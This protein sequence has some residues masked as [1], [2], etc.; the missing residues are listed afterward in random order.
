MQ[1]LIPPEQQEKEFRLTL[2]KF[3]HEI[4]NPLTLI[5]SGLQMM[6][7]SHP[8][9]TGY[10]EW[11]DITENLEYVKDLL[12]ETADYSHAGQIFPE[13]TD[14][15]CLLK[16]IILSFRPCLEYLGITLETDI[17]D[18]LPPL[19]LD[20]IK[21][22]QAFLNL[23]RNAQEAICHS[24]GVIHI[25]A[26]SVPEGV[27]VTVSDNGCGMTEEQQKTIFQPFVTYKQ[28][29]TGLGLSVTRQIIEGHGGKITVHSVPDQGTVFQILFCG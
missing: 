19:Y 22:R 4:R 29:G 3:A 21:I 24:H 20:C 27:R 18:Q 16:S 23:L 8:E 5:Q 9:I 7:A 10:R 26:R 28:G 1:D 17:S 13:K 25:S 12:K 14:L 15:S 11:E 6:A 2:S